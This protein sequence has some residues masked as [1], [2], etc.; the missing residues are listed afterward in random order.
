MREII[1]ILVHLLI[2]LARLARPGGVRSVIAESVMIKHQLLILNRS[3]YERI[4]CWLLWTN[5]HA[6]SSGLAFT[7][8][9]S[10]DW[11]CVGCSEKRF[12]GNLC[13]SISA[14]TMIPCIG[15]ING[16]PICE[17]HK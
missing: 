7:A 4:G 17:F 13:R 11:H 14:R 9:L 6:A 8:E 3:F 16:R 12:N 1:L 10:T 15:S 2:T 5:A